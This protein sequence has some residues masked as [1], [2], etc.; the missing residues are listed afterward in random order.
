[1]S[2]NRSL[3]G[4]KIRNRHGGNTKTFKVYARKTNRHFRRQARELCR[5]MN[6]GDTD[7]ADRFERHR[8]HT[9]AWDAY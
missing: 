1:M 6:R 8:R 7:A 4:R 2:S 3:S 5:L 9:A